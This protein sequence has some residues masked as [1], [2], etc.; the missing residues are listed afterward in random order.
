MRDRNGKP[1][2][3]VGI[4]EDI[5]DQKRATERLAAQE[6][7][8]RRTLEQNVEERTHKLEEANNRLKDEMEQRMVIE[9]ELAKKP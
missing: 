9:G 1:D 8:Y 7:E 3:L 2:Y 4:I 6:A 5:D